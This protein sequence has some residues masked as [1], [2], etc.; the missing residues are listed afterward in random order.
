[1]WPNLCR[2]TDALAAKRLIWLCSGFHFLWR[3]TA[4]ALPAEGDPHTGNASLRSVLVGLKGS[5]RP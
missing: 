1:M 3:L 4:L 2:P 5:V